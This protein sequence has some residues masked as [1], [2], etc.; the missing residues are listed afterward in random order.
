V[1][2][3]AYVAGATERSTEPKL[4]ISSRRFP[5]PVS[6]FAGAA[7]REELGTTDPL[8]PEGA[9]MQGSAAE[10]E[11]ADYYALLN[12]E[13]N[14]TPEQIKRS[15]RKLALRFHPDKNPSAGE[16]FQKISTAH[17][18]LADPQRRQVYDRFGEQGVQMMEQA[19]A[20]G[21]PAWMLN[22]V[23]QSGL[24]GIAAAQFE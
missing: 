2:R 4:R 9:T 8:L 24:L 3:A 23:A 5:T 17:A 14:A 11:A 20:Y 12:L 16:M 19:A 13:P 15:Y 21:V 7:R 18:T 22:P 6:R 10:P 1:K